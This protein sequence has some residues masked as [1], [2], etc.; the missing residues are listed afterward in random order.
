V[1]GLNV[2]IK[3]AMSQSLTSDCTLLWV[4]WTAATEWNNTASSKI[5]ITVKKSAVHIT[6]ENLV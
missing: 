3:T 5:R 1:V 2:R 6:Q 4:T